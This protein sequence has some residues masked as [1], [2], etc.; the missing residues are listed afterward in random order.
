MLATWR[1]TLPA[2]LLASLVVFLVA[3]PLCLG[4][5]IASG[6]PPVAGLLSGIIGGLVV[7]TLGGN[8]YQVSG[9]ANSLIVIVALITQEYGLVGL[10]L[11]TLLAGSMQ[12]AAGLLRLGRMFQAV[13]PS[14]IHGL[15]TGF[16]VIIFASQFHVMLDDTPRASPV[17]NLLSIPQAIWDAAV[18]Q[19][20]SHRAAGIGVLTI[21]LLLLWK[22]LAPGRLARLPASLVA[23]LAATLAVWLLDLPVARVPLPDRL[24]EGIQWLDWAV[25]PSLF[26]WRLVEL[27]A[28]V[29]FLATLETLLCAT[30]VDQLHSGPRTQYDRELAAQGLGNVLCGLVGAVPLTGV[31][32]RSATNLSAGAKTRLA[33]VLHGVWMLLLVLLLPGLLRAIPTAALAAVLVMAV[34]KLIN[35]PA[36]HALW[37]HDRKEIVI[38]AVTAL[39][40]ILVGVLPG[41]AVGLGLAVAKL[42]YHVGF[43]TIDLKQNPAH[44]R[45]IL[46]LRGA[47][48][49]LTLPRLAAALDG[50]PPGW[51]VHVRLDDLHLLDHAAFDF[52]ATWERQYA[53]HG[54]TLLLDWDNLITRFNRPAHVARPAAARLPEGGPYAPHPRSSQAAHVLANASDLGEP[55]YIELK[56]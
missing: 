11:V 34:F 28:T 56:P 29:A 6:A 14:V 55:F 32:I 47:A 25:L 9:P 16:A 48:T 51:H 19:T 53:Q 20:G 45:A 15:M 43:L 30:A 46:H 10:G 1:T 13:P 35:L 24:Q 38:Y 27:A 8:I 42:L 12:V 26:S 33:S 49:F 22:P 50:I 54:G 5:A 21:A 2:D 40:V 52:L 23:V 41:V 36:L 18:A 37:Q 44:R 17:Q 7:A 3:L 39:T 4:I 31:I